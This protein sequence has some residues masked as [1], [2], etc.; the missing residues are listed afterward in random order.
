MKHPMYS[1]GFL[2][3]YKPFRLFNR[4]F[5]PLHLASF[6]LCLA[7]LHN[8]SYMPDLFGVFLISTLA[9]TFSILV[10]KLGDV[11]AYDYFKRNNLDLLPKK[12]YTDKDFE[13]RQENLFIAYLK[14]KKQKICPLIEFVDDSN[15]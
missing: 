14:A 8:I 5:Y 10:Y 4:Y 2:F 9:I 11:A 13:G 12:T 15:D 6:L 3:Q 1:E 7:G